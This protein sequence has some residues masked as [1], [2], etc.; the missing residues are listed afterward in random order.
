MGFSL[1]QAVVI[2]RPMTKNEQSSMVTP[3]GIAVALAVVVALGVLLF[4]SQ[5]FAPPA[6]PVAKNDQ[7]GTMPP[8]GGAQV[9][10]D[11]VRA[12]AP[13]TNTINQT[14]KRMI[15]DVQMG[16]G[17]EAVAG[18]KVTVNYVGK[19]ENGTVF[20]ASAKHGQP[21]T[22]TLGVGQVISGWD[23]GI[24]GMKVGGKRQLVI[25]PE[26]GYGAQAVGSIPPNSTLIFDVE[27]LGVE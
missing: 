6:P 5:L 25:P 27:L 17:A 20:D 4:G 15:T 22:F 19:L 8:T 10:I 16:T 2:L 9:P 23:E 11:G 7:V 18:K 24:T 12:P 26:K 13:T 3:N 14:P 1:Y 21:F